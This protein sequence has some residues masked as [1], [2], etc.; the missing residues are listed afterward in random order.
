MIEVQPCQVSTISLSDGLIRVVSNML[1]LKKPWSS[2]FRFWLCKD[3]ASLFTPEGQATKSNP[4]FIASTG[5]KSIRLSP[6]ILKRNGDKICLI[7]NNYT[8]QMHQKYRIKFFDWSTVDKAKV[9]K[10][11]T[12]QFCNLIIN[13][14]IILS[15]RNHLKN[16]KV[17][18]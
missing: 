18:E 3:L 4:C 12:F 6:V 8:Y 1:P 2:R 5:L 10:P 17:G 9:L 11:R 13:T 7:M 15:T 14:L 16:G